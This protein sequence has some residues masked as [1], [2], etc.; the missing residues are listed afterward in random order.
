MKR[1]FCELLWGASRLMVVWL[2]CP[3]K[4][5]SLSGANVAAHRR[6]GC[7]PL[8]ENRINNRIERLLNRDSA[9]P[10]KN[11]R[12]NITG[13]AVS[14]R[15]HGSVVEWIYD[16][17]K[18]ARVNCAV[19]RKVPVA[20]TLRSGSHARP[21][22]LHAMF[23]LRGRWEESSLWRFFSS[24]THRLCKSDNSRS[25]QCCFPCFCC[26]I[27][28][29]GTDSELQRRPI[30]T[31][32][33]T[34]RVKYVSRFVNFS[35]ASIVFTVTYRKHFVYLQSKAPMKCSPEN[36]R[37]RRYAAIPTG[38]ISLEIGIC[39]FVRRT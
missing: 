37:R 35:T 26:F 12:P 24:V 25:T 34:L 31:T 6:S 33:V 5:T 16:T 8:A 14:T 9:K 19:A 28:S 32:K 39:L 11:W 36:L 2:C 15:R 3:T 7:V 21:H 30:G 23:R 27:A 20:R 17:N 13:R 29:L 1:F 4:F 22:L 38:F 10:P 18:H